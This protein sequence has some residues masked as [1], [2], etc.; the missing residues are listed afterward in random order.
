MELEPLLWSCCSQKTNGTP[1]RETL[2]IWRVQARAEEGLSASTR[3][4][5]PPQNEDRTM[6]WWWGLGLG[7]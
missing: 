3:Y 5:R 2:S 7:G 4:L 1:S 6:G